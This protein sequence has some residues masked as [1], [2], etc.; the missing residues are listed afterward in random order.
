LLWEKGEEGK[1]ITVPKQNFEGKTKKQNFE[2][3]TKKQKSKKEKGRV[4]TIWSAYSVCI[5][6]T[7]FVFCKIHLVKIYFVFISM[8]CLR[9]TSLSTPLFVQEILFRLK[10]HELFLFPRGF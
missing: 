6:I 5:N 1:L 9:V 4:R 2:G 7:S 3:K 8:P 10:N